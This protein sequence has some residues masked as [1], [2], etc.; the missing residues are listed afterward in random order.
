MEGLIH[1]GAY[2]RNFTVPLLHTLFAGGTRLYL[3][4]EVITRTSANATKKGPKLI[5][6]VKK[7][8]LPLFLV[9]LV[10]GC[11]LFVPLPCTAYILLQ[12][13]S[14]EPWKMSLPF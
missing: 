5:E 8:T 10:A 1:G 12:V 6:V 11:T 4:I 7:K 13:Y 14:G 2:F 3:S 9:V